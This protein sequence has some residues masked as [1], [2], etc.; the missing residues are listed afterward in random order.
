V[1]RPDEER[2][3]SSMKE[4]IKDQRIEGLSFGKILVKF[5]VTPY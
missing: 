2:V 3:A 1:R 4:R 5:L